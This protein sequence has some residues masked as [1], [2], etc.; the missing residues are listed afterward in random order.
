MLC[1]FRR[2]LVVGSLLALGFAVGPVPSYSFVE[3]YRV[4]RAPLDFIAAAQVVPSESLPVDSLPVEAV[5]A[6][7]APIESAVSTVEP[8]V[9][10][11][12]SLDGVPTAPVSVRWEDE[13]GWSEWTELEVEVDK[14]PDASTAEAVHAEATSRSVVTQPLWVGT[15][16]AYQVQ[17]SAADAELVGLAEAVV[18]RPDGQ[19]LVVEANDVPAGASVGRPP[20]HPRGEWGAR[21]PST[22]IGSASTLRMSVVHHTATGNDYTAAQVPGIL[23][24]MQAFHMDSNG[25]SDLGYN[26]VVDKFGGVWEG[27]DGSIDRY[28][29][30]AHAEGFNTGSVGVAA[31]GN[32]TSGGASNAQVDAIADTIAWRLAG[33]GIDPTTNV[34]FT[35]GG[36]STIPAGT[37]VD[38][39]RV[40]GHRD[41]GSTDCPGA[42]LYSAISA[43]IRPAMPALVAAKLS[44][45]GIIDVAAGGPG[46]VL[47]SGWVFDPLVINPIDAHVYVD[48]AHRASFAAANERA[49]LATSHP[50]VGTRHGF[51]ESIRGVAPGRHQVCVF[52][53]NVGPGSNTLI[54]CRDVDV[55]SGDPIGVTDAITAGPDGRISLSG[56]VLD[57]DTEDSPE[58]HV[59]V[60]GRGH[61]LG[62]ATGDR[63]DIGSAFPAYGAAH[64]FS[65]SAGGFAP[66]RRSVCVF[67]INEGP[68]TTRWSTCR[69]VV[70]PGGAPIG[71]VDRI[72]G[73]PDGRV[74]VS[75]WSLDPDT[76][77][78]NEVHVYVGSRGFNLG[79]ASQSRPD[80][81]S[82]FPGYGGSHG[83][84]LSVDGFAPGFHPVCVFAI[85]VSGRGPN[86]L[87][88]CQWIG[89]PGGSPF[90]NVESV[91]ASGGR[92]AVTGWAIDP[93]T[94]GGALVHVYIGPQGF[95]A[96]RAATSRTDLAAA[97]PAYGGSHGL[98]WTSPP[99]SSG[100][101]RV[102][103][104]GIN[105]G[106]GGTSLLG[107][108][109]VVV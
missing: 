87:L 98:S 40:I 50:G 24:S 66:G 37:V 23:R 64:G 10:I 88:R 58:V 76:A 55:L 28:S 3:S 74:T 70:V 107:C 100:P 7:A 60:D 18:V 41:I 52:G 69:D 105:V 72:E 78:S 53:I 51:R 101:Q 39:P 45:L 106:L 27:R 65:W 47:V 8:F 80:I 83:F 92:V 15:A 86:S 31:L 90:G 63:P 89:I 84:S 56:W 46:S 20:V 57:P 79:P 30:G 25:W 96:G 29:I 6:D 71:V 12:V 85:D 97:F 22:T 94:A 93:D 44:P 13:S 102:C 42:A 4:D 19:D 9:T 99:V 33:A 95:D 26:F 73:G 17:V 91:T 108:R 1:R 54:G 109:D 77:G 62:R 2:A 38:L 59:Y 11:G 36:S 103:V 49:D 21:A 82:A 16:T 104:Y 48:G 35:S 68:G 61:N 43:R 32:T 5:A 14:G 75:G 34:S 81:G 67:F